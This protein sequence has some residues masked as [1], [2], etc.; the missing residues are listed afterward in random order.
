MSNISQFIPGGNSI[1]LWASGVSVA[2]WETVKSPLD[3][4]LYTRKAA[5]GSGTT[6]PADDTTNYFAAS[7][8]RCGAMLVKP[9]ASFLSNGGSSGN[10]G[11]AYGIGRVQ[12]G[13]IGNNVRTLI[14]SQTGRGALMF[15]GL[16]AA[17][18][19]P[20]RVEVLVDGRSV[21]D[22]TYPGV[23]ANQVCTLLGIVT[24]G[25]NPSGLGATQEAFGY[26]DPLGPKFRRTLQ[27][28]VTGSVGIAAADAFAIATRSEA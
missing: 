6:D 18:N 11:Y 15:L 2:K 8:E 7:F 27:I 9:A 3:G 25:S 13:V 23:A 19:K 14:H 17:T 4:E 16:Y 21:L 28:Y 12:P 20:F 22:A 24:P 1:K 10:G 26:P 5:T